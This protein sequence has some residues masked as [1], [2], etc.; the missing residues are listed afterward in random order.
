MHPG[1][2]DGRPN[3]HPYIAPELFYIYPLRREGI[4]IIALYP[5]EIIPNDFNFIVFCGYD[6]KNYVESKVKLQPIE[7]NGSC[8][9]YS[10]VD[11]KIQIVKDSSIANTVMV[12]KEAKV[13]DLVGGNFSKAEDTLNTRGFKTVNRNQTT[14]GYSVVWWFHP[15]TGQCINTESKDNTLLMANTGKVPQCGEVAKQA[16]GESLSLQKLYW[17]SLEWFNELQHF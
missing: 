6:I 2:S 3:G 8:G 1:H 15:E 4:E 14:D 7:I 17:A 9:I 5:S 11:R 10:I 12:G 16:G 13:W